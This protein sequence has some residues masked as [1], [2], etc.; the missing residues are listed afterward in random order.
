MSHGK[1]IKN[2]SF[3]AGALIKSV[4]DISLLA[5]VPLCFLTFALPFGPRHISQRGVAGLSS[6]INP[7]LNGAKRYDINLRSAGA[8]D[9]PPSK[10]RDA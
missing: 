2:R 3:G 6:V 4:Y 7:H 9:V 10:R 8:A 1:V 5:L